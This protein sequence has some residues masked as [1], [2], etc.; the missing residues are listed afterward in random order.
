M[1]FFFCR[2]DDQESLAAKTIIG[3]IARQLVRHLPEDAF[4]QLNESPDTSDILEVLRTKL[5][6][7]RHY[8]IV[9]GLDECGDSQAAEVV[10]FL[11]ELVC[12]SL[13]VQIFWTSRPNMTISL[14]PLFLDQQISLDSADSQHHIA[15]D[16]G[17]YIQTTLEE[18]LDGDTP[19]LKIGDPGVILTIADQ[20]EKRAYGMLV[21]Y[22]NS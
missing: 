9:D 2:F 10:Q 15:S 13:K 22:S 12:S 14:K 16:I 18:W 19:Q 4:H 11:E 20:L 17:K 6:S 8:I 3:S 5:G 1:S 7:T 21:L